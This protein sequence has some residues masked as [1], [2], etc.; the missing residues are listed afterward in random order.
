MKVAGHKRPQS[1]GVH[2]REGG[3]NVLELETTAVQ[4]NE[5][6]QTAHLTMVSFMLCEFYLH[7]KR[8]AQGAGLG[9]ERPL[10]SAVK[11]NASC[12]NQ[13]L[14][15]TY[16]QVLPSNKHS[17]AP[18]MRPTLGQREGELSAVQPTWGPPPQRGQRAPGKLHSHRALRPSLH[19]SLAQC[20]PQ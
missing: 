18:P 19:L 16:T 17:P 2:I 3:E 12:P 8:S 5:C 1:I 9:L 6:H 4:L 7:R 13:H 14:T 20:C 11:N 10:Q 15:Q